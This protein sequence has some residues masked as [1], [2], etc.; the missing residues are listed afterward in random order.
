LLIKT[1]AFREVSKGYSVN[2]NSKITILY[3]EDDRVTAKSM[4]EILEDLADE[5]LFASNGAEAL[6][7]L[8]ECS[9]DL[10]I[11]DINMPGMSGLELARHIREDNTDIPILMITAE[12][13]H[14]YLIEG[15]KLKIDGYILKPIDLFQFLEDINRI[16][17]DIIAKREL[18]ESAKILE[19]YKEVIDL[20]AI[21][22]KADVD[23]KITYVNDAFCNVTGY[24]RE[25]LIGQN[26]SIIRHLE[27]PS[28]VFK[29]MWNT[30]QNKK[31]WEGIIKNRKK[32]GGTYYVK[33]LVSPIIDSN[34][35]IIEYIGIRQDIT[36]LELYKQD[37][38]KQL[39]Y[40]TKEIIDTQKEVVFTMGAIGETR[41][42]ET[43]LHVARVAEYSYL[44]GKLY[45]LSEEDATLLKQAS[46][47]HDIGKVGIPDAI[48]NKSGKLTEEEFE[49]MKSH[50]EIGYEMLNHSNKSILKAAAVIAYQHHEKWDGSG[51]PNKLKGEEIH[52][53]GRIT[54]IADVFDALGH[55]RVYKK[56]WPL[57]KILAMFDENKGK[58]FDPQL[59]DIVFDN[60]DQ[61]LDIQKRF[62]D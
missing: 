41:S 13:E 18:L 56:A 53:Y 9:I 52:V 44:L 54:T 15:I 62:K 19:E 30:I 8:E 58:H 61:I 20:S 4:G 51:Y 39:S 24:T 17:K 26:H 3:V 49:V 43:G 57:E 50:S 22:S 55:D 36:E 60:L 28:S 25:E 35:N 33:S 59:I 23:G 38:E 14:Q 31:N 48:L 42:K 10:V 32:D 21:V 12:N 37:I 34:D 40:A 27:T 16:I 45:G 5:V 29:V 46:P 2:M 7:L 11:T 1:K 6:A 47:M